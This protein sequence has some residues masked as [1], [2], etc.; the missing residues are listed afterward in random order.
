MARAYR[1]P[2]LTSQRRTVAQLRA[3]G[4]PARE[5]AEVFGVSLRTIYRSAA[6]S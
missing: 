3:E 1:R 4:K 5:L 2:Q 6:G